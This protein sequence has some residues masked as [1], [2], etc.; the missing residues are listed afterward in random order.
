MQADA[1]GKQRG[2]KAS[3]KARVAAGGAVDKENDGAVGVGGSSR[4]SLG[5]LSA[6]AAAAQPRPKP[7]AAA[8]SKPDP[9]PVSRLEHRPLAALT[10]R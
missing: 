7:A 8:A 1:A 6:A 2:D 4:G 5:V 3:G 10:D 9:V